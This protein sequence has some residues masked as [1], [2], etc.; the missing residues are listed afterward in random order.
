MSIAKQNITLT[1]NRF[2]LKKFNRNPPGIVGV[3]FLSRNAKK[4][5]HNE[6]LLKKY[7]ETYQDMACSKKKFVTREKDTRI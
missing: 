4:Y 5:N 2:D 3:V 6:R 7:R 1:K